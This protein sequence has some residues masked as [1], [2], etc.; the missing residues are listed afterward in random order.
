MQP[1]LLTRAQAAAYLGIQASRFDELGFAPFV[2][3]RLYR[4]DRQQLDAFLDGIHPIDH[5]DF[6][7]AALDRFI[8]S[9]REV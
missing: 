8:R 1:R 2:I 9:R 5:D 6:P 4:F 3:A 7:E